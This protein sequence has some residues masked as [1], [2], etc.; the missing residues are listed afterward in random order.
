ML[1][2]LGCLVAQGVSRS[3]TAAASLGPI[4]RMQGHAAAHDSHNVIRPSSAVVPPLR[5]MS[6]MIAS[7]RLIGRMGV[8]NGWAR[9]R[10]T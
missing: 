2:Q 10:F 3:A 8:I 7:P 4:A 1:P 5:C 6:L 9:L